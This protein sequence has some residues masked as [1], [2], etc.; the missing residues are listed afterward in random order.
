MSYFLGELLEVAIELV[1]DHR[2]QLFL[3]LQLLKTLLSTWAVLVP[4]LVD[5]DGS[6]FDLI[7]ADAWDGMI[8]FY[9]PL[10]WLLIHLFNSL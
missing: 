5:F 3:P 1:M 4:R 6:H 10:L 8:D 7:S 2:R 9:D